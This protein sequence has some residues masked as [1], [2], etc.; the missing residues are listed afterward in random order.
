MR[1]ELMLVVGAGGGILRR[2]DEGQ[3]ALPLPN[4]FVLPA[5]VR[6]DEA[7]LEMTL[8]ILRRRAK[9]LLGRAKLL[10]EGFPR[11]LGTWNSLWPASP[12]RRPRRQPSR[13]ISPPL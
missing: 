12:L 11:L 5:Q 2:R 13:P 8:R 4:G 7:E 1:H 10:L 3:A 9:L 6:E